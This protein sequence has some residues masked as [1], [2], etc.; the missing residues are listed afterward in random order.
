MEKSI[1]SPEYQKVIEKLVEIRRE[2]GMTQCQLAELMGREQSFIW[3]LEKGERRL[4][5]IEFH[6]ICEALNKKAS[7]VYSEIMDEIQADEITT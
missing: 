2:A 6:W 5:L 7:V 3:R 1:H 4:D